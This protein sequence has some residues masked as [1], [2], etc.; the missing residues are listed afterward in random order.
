MLS[1]KK[2]NLNK[3]LLSALLSGVLLVSMSQGK[4]E[5]PPRKEE[6][7]SP[8]SVVFAEDLEEALES[9]SREEKEVVEE[10]L[11][12]TSLN[13]QSLYEFFLSD[14]FASGTSDWQDKNQ[15]LRPLSQILAY[16]AALFCILIWPLPSLATK[17]KEKFRSS[18]SFHRFSLMSKLLTVLFILLVYFLIPAGKRRWLFYFLV[19]ASVLMLALA[20]WTCF[21]R[22]HTADEIHPVPDLE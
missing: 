16:I 15:A 5:L 22:E 6:L 17:F 8:V 3:Q 4:I 11:M 13:L 14:C 2:K 9:E 7:N 12:K 21:K 20:I 18:L 1:Q 10:K 19:F